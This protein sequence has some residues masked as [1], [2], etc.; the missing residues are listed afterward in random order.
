MSILKVYNPIDI[1]VDHGDGVYLYAVDGTRF[2]DFTSGIGVNCLGHSHPSLVNALKSQGEK[3]WHCSNLFKV[4]GQEAVAEKLVKNSFASN[5]FFCNSGSEATETSIKVARK[6]FYEKGYTS[7]NRI[8]TF[9]GAF[10]GRTLAS[11][12]AAKNPDHTRGFGPDVEGFDQVPFG[13]HEALEKAVNKDTA[14]IMVETILGE[15]GI[16][17]I[18]EN[19][20][21]GLRKLCDERDILLILDEVQCGLG[22]TGKL[23]AFEWAKI[24]P[25]IVPI[26]K[27]IGG[28]FPLG[29]CLMNKKTASTMSPGSHG[30]TFGGNPLAMSIATVV[31]DYILNEDFLKNVVKVGNYLK[32]RL[33][34]E[35]IKK[36]PTLVSGIRGKGLMLGI[37]SKIKN[38]V[39]IKEMINYK[40]L[41]VKASQ[42]VI[43]ILPPLILEEKHV[44]EAIIKIN[45][46]FKNLL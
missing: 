29:A 15:G 39:L 25:D 31:L 40:L 23:F 28:G 9:E 1:E 36:Y 44:D 3:I 4:L 17:V 26:A 38:E 33:E 32:T 7:K 20:L 16:R 12:F 2:L 41:T 46:A 30:S 27:G 18:P 45:K 6:F 22:R 34:E 11:L 42:N 14:A 5:V 10:H 21:K 43:R 35:V 19:C 37:E 24:K 8:I 13:D